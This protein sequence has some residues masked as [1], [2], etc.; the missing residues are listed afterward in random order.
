MTDNDEEFTR[1]EWALA[2]A[3]A[4]WAVVPVWARVEA[5]EEGKWRC[6]CDKGDACPRPAK[7][8]I[9][10]QGTK[11]AT[12]DP[13]RI[14]AWWSEHPDANIAIATGKN[15]GCI[16]IDVDTADGKSGDVALTQACA[17]HGG[18]PRTLKATSGS[19]GRHY[20][21]R[22]RE[23]PF[24]RKIGFLKAVDYLS[25][26]GYVIVQPSCNLK[27][28][29]A[30]DSELQVGSPETL[31][32]LREEMAELPAWFDAL[33]GTGR[34]GRRAAGGDARAARASDDARARLV[35]AAAMEFSATNPRWVEEVRSALTY[36]DPD[37]RDDWVLFGIILGREFE[38]ADDGWVLY[39]EWASRSAK[40]SDPGTAAAMR[41]YYYTDSLDTPQNGR[42]ATIATIL[43]RAAEAGYALPR[44][45]LDARRVVAYRAGRAVETI[46][47][48]LT[49]LARERE[50]D[51][52]RALRI[53][54]FGSGLG[55]V[56]ETHDTGARYTEDGR[57]PN[58]WVLRVSP[59]SS[60]SLGSRVT[61]TATIVKF[62]ATGSTQQ[63]ECP[64]EVSTLLLKDCTKHFPRL[65]GIV[66]W[67][68]VIGG[69]CVG[70]AE[71]Y[72][73]VAGL[74]FALPDKMDLTDIPARPTKEMAHDAWL[75]IRDVALAGF[76]F[77]T[78]RDAA[79]ALA[80]LLT[81]QQRRAMESAPAFLITAP[82][83]GTGKTS[84][85]KFAS[86]AVHGRTLG[87]GPLSPDSEEQRK[88][89]TAALLSNPPAL[90]FDNL[91]AGSS[92]NSNELAI[93]M[94]SG[95]W[96]DRKLGSTER[97][98]LPNRAVWCFTGNNVTPRSDLRRRFCIIRL[99][100]RTV[101]HHEQ[102]FQRDIDR[103][104]TE[105]REQVLRALTTILLWAAHKAPKLERE[106]GFPQ[107]DTEVRRA[108]VGVT[109]VD[110]FAS[111]ADTDSEEDEEEG[112]IAAVM[113]S[114]ALLVGAD[115]SKVSDWAAAVEAS[116]KSA[117]SARK[118]SSEAVEAA[119]AT[120]RE[121]P[122]HKL[123]ARDYGYALRALR[124][125]IV[126]VSGVEC[127]FRQ[128]DMRDKVARWVLVGAEALKAKM[129]EEF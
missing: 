64:P 102:V 49:L 85:V 57:P 99:V 96:E 105:N 92:F 89:I 58:G 128:A 14:E 46:D 6:A 41:S 9:P 20:W 109:G 16:V 90:L 37:S 70:L 88:A 17:P 47:T 97:L 115:R 3:R 79:G 61:H 30:W 75:W 19:G 68:M 55:S 72:D 100:A 27:G 119:I 63:V 50:S 123:E 59:H 67:P 25:D 104:P 77:D 43:A 5:E 127:S 83:I 121:T 60:M 33:E 110:P 1:L 35:N 114:W 45:G 7:H 38:R 62:S 87:A 28:A 22:W 40:F 65:N 129:E 56:I 116:K 39:E 82:K 124:D 120:L 86:R 118:L 32:R 52:D 36:C 24:T 26:G 66:Q 111:I 113:K 117:D 95:E 93:A 23:S 98:T 51:A 12:T 106:S 29:Y 10:R 21:Y 84:L 94:T 4:G 81:F 76:P 31:G 73:P 15:S 48:L 13:A 54:A 53:Y 101:A 2:Y 122:A 91:P 74:V 8:P 71:D 126:V 103:W 34:T 42:P 69:R 78:E 108:V 18:V 125:R 44:N 112:A 107:W 11:Q 80:L